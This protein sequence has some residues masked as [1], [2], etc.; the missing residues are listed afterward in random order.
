MSAKKKRILIAVSVLLFVI[1][2]ISVFFI[3]RWQ[4]SYTA[5]VLW[6]NDTNGTIKPISQRDI[7]LAT[8]V[9]DDKGIS[10]ELV[11]DD[12]LLVQEYNSKKAARL[13]RSC[14]FD[15]SYV[16]DI[17]GTVFSEPG[18]HGFQTPVLMGNENSD[19]LFQPLSN[20]DIDQSCKIL[21]D[22][23][24][25]YDVHM[26]MLLVQE[27]DA[28]KAISLLSAEDFESCYIFES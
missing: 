21:S 19:F 3:C 11:N 5:T 17:Y 25:E 2:A 4:F 20:K 12:T 7:S 14:R 24:I 15:S 28:E 18:R 26:F 27:D 23:G 6:A 9:L 16:D 8:Q 10:Y 1:L 22:N 13:L